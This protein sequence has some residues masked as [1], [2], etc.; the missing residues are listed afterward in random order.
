[1]AK[2]VLVVDD[3]ESIRRSLCQVLTS[4]AEFEISAEAENGRDAID[5]ALALR[6]DVIVMDVSMPVM[7]G[8]DAARALRTLLPSVPVIMFSAYADAFSTSE[9]CRIGVAA[10]ISKA[11]HISALLERIR[12]LRGPIAA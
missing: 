11:E 8:I 9:A 7:N 6:P 4:E 1:M 12:E 10:F 5:K 2:K 3:N